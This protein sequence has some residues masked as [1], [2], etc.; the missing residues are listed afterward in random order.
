MDNLSTGYEKVIAIAEPILEDIASMNIAM[1]PVSAA[2]TSMERKH[3]ARADR[4]FGM[5]Y[6][7]LYSSITRA[8]LRPFLQDSARVSQPPEYLVAR[9]QARLKTKEGLSDTVRFIH[10]LSHNDLEI[11]WPAWSA[12]A[13]SS[14]CFQILLMATSGTEA[15]DAAYWVTCLQQVRRDMRLKADVLHCLR[16]GLL[17]IDSIFWK[18]PDN[19]LHLDEHVRQAFFDHSTAKSSGAEEAIS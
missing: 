13:F 17:R 9:K 12:T 18:G 1:H 4:I 10:S 16:L 2:S 19:V 11:M 3:I 5:S 6:H 7:Y 14:I 8:L 15:E